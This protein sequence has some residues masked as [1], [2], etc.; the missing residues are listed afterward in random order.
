MR[1]Y[2]RHA[3]QR[4]WLRLFLLSTACSCASAQAQDATQNSVLQLPAILVEGASTSSE[5]RLR[6]PS[7]ISVM[8]GE[9]A[10]KAGV[11]DQRDLARSFANVTGFDAGGNRMTT[12]SM[13]SMREF[14]YQSTPGAYP[15]FAYYVDDVPALTTLG[16]SSLLMNLDQVEVLRGPQGTRFGYSPPGG[17][18]DIHSRP[19]G[20]K[21]TGYVSGSF[22][23]RSAYE[24]A[25]GI[26]TPIGSQFF[27]SADGVLQGRN[28]F[29]NNVALGDTYGDK[30]GFAGRVRLSWRPS[31]RFEVDLWTQHER[32]RDQ[33][34]PFIPLS[35]LR[36][37]PFSLSYNDP[38]HENITQDLQALRIKSSFDGFDLLSVSAYRRSTWDFVNDGDSTAAA[39]DPANPYSRY[40]GLTY[41]SVKSFTQEIRLKSNDPNARFQ[42][43]VGMFGA[44][45]DIGIQPGAM[46]YP[47]TRSVSVATA[48][49][50]DLAAFGAA[51]YALTD[52]LRIESGLRYQWAK[53]TADNSFAAPSISHGSDSYSAVLP[54]AAVVFSPMAGISTYAKYTR[55]FRPGGFNAHK[56]VTDPTTFA[57]KS[58]LSD[59][60]EIGAKATALDGRLS[61]GVSVY[62]TDYRNYQVLNQFS[63]RVAGVNNAQRVDGRG[64]E[65]EVS[66]RVTP[67]LRVFGSAGL[68]YARYRSF[69][70]GYS[71]FS[72]NDVPF[73][74]RFT[75]NYGVEYQ[76]L[77]GGF[78]SV[79]A[80]TTGSYALDD[81]GTSRQGAFTVVDGQIG[82]RKDNYEFAVFGKNIFN[83]RYIANVYDFSG[84]GISAMGNLGDPAT[85]GVRARVTF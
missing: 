56:N 79:S 22:G 6:T 73:V 11:I 55:G 44:T 54:S 46:L 23:T 61:M 3:F 38:G 77:W 70:N 5:E 48:R 14:G 16:R 52:S 42:W 26:S 71:D 85:Y 35:Q 13:R 75:L 82:Y 1:P 12:Y 63:A 39:Y 50:D 29:Y 8:T 31:D 65:A 58:E 49:N 2:S 78:A 53:R 30:Q 27:L 81:K 19:A 57:Y 21:P 69:K 40:S 34:D 37:N 20:S 25:A 45:T 36:T 62:V 68:A 66:Y 67:E 24:T 72:H 15:A 18:I 84:T 64:A 10:Q 47:A 41:E 7:S 28:G 33:S 60:F 74:P 32:F 59:N 51:S 43:S 17:V 9:E 76:A 4:S 80:R 83:Q